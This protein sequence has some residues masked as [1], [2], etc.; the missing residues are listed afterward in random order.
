MFLDFDTLYNETQGDAFASG[1]KKFYDDKVKNITTTLEEGKLNIR[2]S[3]EGDRSYSCKITFDEQGGLYDYSCDCGHFTLE[4]GPCKHIVATALSYEER[5]P[6][7][8][9]SEKRKTDAGAI[10]LISEYNKKK[11]RRFVTGD[12]L[13]KRSLYHTSSLTRAFRCGLR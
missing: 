4:S 12:A 2:A 7:V 9:E 1:K 11:R 6:N 8:R 3:V 13:Q 5:N 10:T